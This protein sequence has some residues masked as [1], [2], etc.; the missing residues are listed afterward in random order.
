M[1]EPIAYLKG[2]FVPASECVLPI[3]DLGIVIG[4][5]VTDF[6]RTFHQ[7]PYRL[8]DHLQRLYRS[9]RYARIEPPV[10]I[11]ES[12]EIS[13]KLIANN[14]QLA[15]GEELGLVFYMTA[16]E[17]A[18]YAGAA[19]M[20]ETLTP[21]YVQHTFPIRFSLFRNV[22]LEGVHCVTPAPRHWPPQCLSS[23]IK[24]RNRLHMWIGEQEVKQLDPSA[25]PLYLDING[26]ITETGGSNFVIYRDGQVVSPRRDNIL[27]GISLTVLGEI[28]EE[29]GIPLV[30]E[31]LQ[32][33][34][35]VNAEE[36]WMPTT[37]YCLGPV[38]RFNGEPIGDGQPGPLWRKI[39]D[40]WSE[41]VDKDIY[42]EVA[43]A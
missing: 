10:S 3:Y 18:V 2:E 41:V 27:W 28:L 34:D 40:R 8:E 35:V 15:P 42:Q 33:Y 29:M 26:N 13:E 19:G 5:A 7:V 4:A 1:T 21:S 20:P 9:C 43:S 22:F 14:S 36:A 25:T 17:N 24:N 12:R 23:K 6:F 31:N 39:I 32:T 16:G 38:T 11:E 37:P 30:E